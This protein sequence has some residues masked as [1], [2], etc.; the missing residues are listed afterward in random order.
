MTNLRGSQVSLQG[1]AELVVES[2]AK[3]YNLENTI[4]KQSLQVLSL[5][6]LQA[7][8][9]EREMTKESNTNAEREIVLKNEKTDVFKFDGSRKETDANYI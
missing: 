5:M 9:N 2:W 4:E 7:I 1:T 3:L 8:E 6:V